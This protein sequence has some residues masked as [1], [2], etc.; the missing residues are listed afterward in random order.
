MLPLAIVAERILFAAPIADDH[1]YEAEY[2]DDEYATQSTMTHWSAPQD[3]TLSIQDPSTM[4]QAAILL[5]A[6]IFVSGAARALQ[7]ATGDAFPPLQC[8]RWTIFSTTTSVP[9]GGWNL[10]SAAIAL[11]NTTPRE[12][13]K[14]L[15]KTA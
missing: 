11:L 7:T 15:L 1:A 6:T 3:D 4:P 2:P 13:C 8:S 14:H 12:A 9:I 5:A 10:S